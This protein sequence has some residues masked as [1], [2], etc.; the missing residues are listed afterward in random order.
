[1]AHRQKYTEI[2]SLKK[3]GLFLLAIQ[4]S[5]AV[6]VNTKVRVEGLETT[7]A[8]LKSIQPDSIKDIRAEIRSIV[9]TSGAVSKI[10]S[11]TPPI[12]PLSGMANNG[13]TKWAGVKSVSVSVLPR[14]APVGK[15][16][17]PLVRISA[18]GGANSLGFDYAELAG[19]RRR[20][21]RDRSKIRGGTLRGTR[22]GDGSMALRG[23]GDNFIKVLEDRNGKTPGRFAF[24][25]VFETRGRIMAGIQET[26]DKYAAKVNR[27]LK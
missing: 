24:R 17:S 6:F 1:L 14:L 22:K 25:A 2:D 20:P 27:K 10:R 11:R 18:T 26:L 5:K 12:A 15:K 23:Q 21:P 8:I 9:T 13:P 19:I 16:S 7:L 3:E 4:L